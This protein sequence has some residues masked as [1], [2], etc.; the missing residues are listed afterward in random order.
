MKTPLRKYTTPNYESNEQG[1]FGAKRK[2][3]IHTGIDLYCEEN[4]RVYSEV[5]G[6]VHKIHPFT[7]AIANSP[8]W[9]DTLAVMVYH[10]EIQKTFLY[11][12]I[13]TKI[14]VG[15]TVKAG[16]EIGRVKTVLK[17]D[18]GKPMTMLHMECYK[19]L[20]NNA[21]WWY[22]DKKCPNNLEDITKYL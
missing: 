10:P 3:D 7:G 2:Y 8:W 18:K 9:N 16:Q 17:K 15:R 20:Q 14:K 22:H 12:E 11:G 13:L 4:D 5:D 1:M 21:V 6:I 19:G